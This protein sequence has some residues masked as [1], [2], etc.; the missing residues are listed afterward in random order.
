MTE[1]ATEEPNFGDPAAMDD[2]GEELDRE[3]LAE[4]HGIDPDELA[5]PARQ[6]GEVSEQSQQIMDDLLE[7]GVATPVDDEGVPIEPAGEEA[8]TVPLSE[9]DIEAPTDVDADEDQPVREVDTDD[10]DDVQSD[11]SD[12]DDP[13]SGGMWDKVNQRRAESKQTKEEAFGQD[14]PEEENLPDTPTEELDL[15]DDGPDLTNW[16]EA[17]QFT[18]KIRGLPVTFS[19]PDSEDALVNA[20]KGCEDPEDMSALRFAIASEVVTAIDGFEMELD[21]ETWDQFSPSIKM[22]VGNKSLNLTGVMD[23]GVPSAGGRE[24]PSD[25]TAEK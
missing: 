4:E 13:R 17:A 11:E 1:Q 18:Q 10:E 16:T 2:S 19:E 9:T 3:A 15:E 6:P 14:D 5:P 20:I 12:G 25:G 21:R 7:Q 24:R 22:R 8:E 23:F